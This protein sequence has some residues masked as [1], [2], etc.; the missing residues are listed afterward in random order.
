MIAS[1]SHSIEE[2]SQA[3]TPLWA[4]CILFLFQSVA[5]PL[6]ELFIMATLSTPAAAGGSVAVDD[7][8][9]ALSFS[10]SSMAAPDAQAGP[11]FSAKTS[12]L[13]LPIGSG[14]FITLQTDS[15]IVEASQPPPAPK[16]S[17]ICGI[18]FGSKGK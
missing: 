7:T 18:P 14:K 13:I 6:V 17:S 15:L 11:S 16:H 5:S 2:G 1:L 10:S 12:D 9:K 3:N 4:W 8:T